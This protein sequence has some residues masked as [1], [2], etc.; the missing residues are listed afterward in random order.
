V[1]VKDLR[2]ED[3]FEVARTELIKTLRVEL[4]QAAAMG[5]SAYRSRSATSRSGLL[6]DFPR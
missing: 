5:L 2:R 4:E 1:T 6:T 3:Q